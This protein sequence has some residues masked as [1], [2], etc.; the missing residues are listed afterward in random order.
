V[1]A[2]RGDDS[3]TFLDFLFLM[4]LVML[5]L[6]NPKV[7]PTKSDAPPPGHMVI[8]IDWP[9]G[10]TD[11]DGWIKDPLEPR[12]IGYSRKTGKNWSLVRD[13]VGDTNDPTPMNRESYISRAAPAGHYVFNLHL[14]RG[15]GPIEVWVEVRLFE[16]G[17]SRVIATTKATLHRYGQEIT[18]I[19]FDLDDKGKASGMNNVF[20]PLR[21]AS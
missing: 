3:T 8:T 12:A 20:Q 17:K 11:V 16:N 13:D 21:S 6:V 1:R 2:R 9:V 15:A 18:V 10:N 7:P 4:V 14:F 19:A 5:L